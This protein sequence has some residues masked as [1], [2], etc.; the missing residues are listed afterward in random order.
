M[1]QNESACRA[2]AKVFGQELVAAIR[3]WIDQSGHLE[4]RRKREQLIDTFPLVLP[5]LA[6]GPSDPERTPV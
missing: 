5:A 2:I 4:V 1:D 6:L 3:D